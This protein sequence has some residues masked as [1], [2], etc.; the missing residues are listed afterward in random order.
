MSGNFPTSSRA[1][2]QSFGTVSVR[3][4]VF[5]NHDP[6]IYDI[7]YP[8]E[9]AW[10]NTV[11]FGI[12][13]LETLISANGVVTA[14]WRALAPTVLATRDP[15]SSDYHYPISQPWVDTTDNSYWILTGVSGTIAN[16][17]LLARGSTGPILEILPD[18]GTTPVVPNAD[19]E[20]SIL[21]QT[22]PSVSGIRTTGTLNGL[23]ISMFSPFV[24]DFTF[25]D[26]ASGSSEIVTVR[27]TSN[28]AG[29]NAYFVSQTGGTSGGIAGTQYSNTT[30]TVWTSG[31]ESPTGSSY[32]IAVGNDLTTDP[33]MILAHNSTSAIFMTDVLQT[34]Q[35][36]P[37]SF[38]Q[39]ISQNTSVGADASSRMSITTEDGGGDCYLL[40]DTHFGIPTASYEV[41]QTQGDL[42]QI[43]H[44]IDTTSANMTGTKLFTL[45]TTGICTIEGDTTILNGNFTLATTGNKL[46]IATGVNASIGTATLAAG[47]VVVPTTAVT[48]SSKI[49]VT[50]DTVGGTQGILSVPTASII[51]GTSFVINSSNAGDVSTV[52]WWVVN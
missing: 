38:V 49:F 41:G 6:S 17:V 27:N 48:A 35:S 3:S 7:T 26:A 12:W 24:G 11:T 13:I 16:W 45:T 18:T 8:I 15:N 44:T 32:V 10:V 2:A 34:S 43:T 28:T 36:N 14:Q 51:A 39:V 21:G 22:P 50:C 20:V 33:V 19:G 4:P 52:N 46:N 30:D 37:T 23:N 31:I 47:T 9:Q 25:T 5:E 29:S 40:F 42:F 1:Y